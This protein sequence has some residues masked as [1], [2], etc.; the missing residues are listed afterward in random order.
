M[1]AIYEE[2]VLKIISLNDEYPNM[3]EGSMIGGVEGQRQTGWG[4]DSAINIELQTSQ[5]NVQSTYVLQG[6]N[7]IIINKYK[8]HHNGSEDDIKSNNLECY[9]NNKDCLSAVYR[10]IELSG[11]TI[12]KDETTVTCNVSTY[13]KEIIVH[14]H[15]M[16]LSIK[17]YSSNSGSVN[18][19]LPTLADM[20]SNTNS[21]CLTAAQGSDC[22]INATHMY[23]YMAPIIG[24]LTMKH[25]PTLQNNGFD[26]L[27]SKTVDEQK[28]W[29]AMLVYC[30]PSVG[31]IGGCSLTRFLIRGFPDPV[32]ESLSFAK[33]CINS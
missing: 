31:G 24:F 7:Q 29:W 12:N 19:P 10:G 25:N 4:I 23:S 6:D 17:R 27:E 2:R 28:L 20:I 8:I 13:G 1:T 21:N 26:A 14:E 22:V 32:S 16:S 5:R 15:A 11:L 18:D 33:L 9:N 30:D 3:W